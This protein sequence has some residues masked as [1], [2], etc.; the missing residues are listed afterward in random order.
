MTLLVWDEELLR[1]DPAQL[2][3]Q[4]SKG[5]EGGL[6][7]SRRTLLLSFNDAAVQCSSSLPPAM[8]AHLLANI[9]HNVCPHSIFCFPS[10][11]VIIN[12]SFLDL[13]PPKNGWSFDFVWG[14]WISKILHRL[15]LLVRKRSLYKRP[16]MLSKKSKCSNINGFC[17]RQ[18]CPWCLLPPV[19]LRLL[20]C[21][22][23]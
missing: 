17:W 6:P 8:C 18:F 21:I 15:P 23:L 7:S 19:L 3:G 11:Y 12:S 22:K 2:W 5:T 1:A 9:F 16:T 20:S 13:A 4:I 10:S 14:G